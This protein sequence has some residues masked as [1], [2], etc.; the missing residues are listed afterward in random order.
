MVRR[1]ELST[2]PTHSISPSRSGRRDN[3]L[4]TALFDDDLDEDDKQ[5]AVCKVCI[6]GVGMRHECGGQCFITCDN[7]WCTSGLKWFEGHTKKMGTDVPAFKAKH[8]ANALRVQNNAPIA[9]ARARRGA[10]NHQIPKFQNNGSD[11][12]ED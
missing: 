8:G 4:E 9:K 2:S 6:G 12:K 1:G 10:A 7:V 3:R 11:E 5:C